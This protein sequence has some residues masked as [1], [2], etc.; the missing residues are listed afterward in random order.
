MGGHDPYSSSKGC[1]ELVT[2]AYRG[3]FLGDRGVAVASARAGNVI[4]GGDWSEDRLV[5]D[6]MEAAAKGEPALLRHPEAVRPWQY[7]LEPLR[8]YLM[9]GRALVEQ[10]AAVAEAWNFGPR[11]DDL[12]TVGAV[13]QRMQGTWGRVSVRGTGADQGPREAGFLALDCTKARD[14]LGW[15]PVLT[16]DA[17]VEMT[18]A[19]YKAHY[20][21]PEASQHLVL[22][23]LRRYAAT[24][25]Q[26]GSG[27]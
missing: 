13:A 27:T 3:S 11:D 14:R 7:V 22:Q 9:L 4:G 26:S 20:E 2:A 17:A 25:L 10:G 16:L 12:A 23:D 21:D 6:L 15:A 8:G 5:P 24:V 18:V 1:A 19:W